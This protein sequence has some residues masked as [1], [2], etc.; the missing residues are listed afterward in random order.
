MILARLEYNQICS[1]GKRVFV[2]GERMIS[3][4]LMSVDKFGLQLAVKTV[5]P[6]RNMLGFGK[7]IGKLD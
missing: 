5:E 2:H 6:E 1:G 7:R 4:I 3:R